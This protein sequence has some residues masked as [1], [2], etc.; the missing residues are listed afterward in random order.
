MPLVRPKHRWEDNIK[1]HLR[2]WDGRTWTRLIWLK[3]ETVGG[4]L[5]MR[6]WTFHK[7]RGIFLLAENRLA[8]QEGLYCMESVSYLSSC[9]LQ[10]R[11]KRMC[12]L[13]WFSLPFI[14]VSKWS[15][16]TNE[17]KSISRILC[18]NLFSVS[19]AATNDTNM[20]IAEGFKYYTSRTFHLLPQAGSSARS[21]EWN[22]IFRV[23]IRLI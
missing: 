12:I 9:F 18:E 23:L 3:V 14:N 19:R 8:C 17:L 10:A 6:Q 15:L 1:M 5:W 22:P 7:I 11:K 16:S 21:M 20:T 13:H 4:H 2:K